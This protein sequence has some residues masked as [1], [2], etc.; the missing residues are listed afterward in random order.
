MRLATTDPVAFGQWFE[1]LPAESAQEVA[2]VSFGVWTRAAPGAA[3]AY[4]LRPG[5]PPKLLANATDIWT[6]YEPDRATAWLAAGAKLVWVVYPN[7]RKVHVHQP[8]D[9][10]VVLA[11]NDSLE[12]PGLF[13]G[14][15]MK[16]SEIFTSR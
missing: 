14:W 9:N 16:V 12:A 3:I 8:G 10:P 11:E 7:T 4:A 13:P 15:S 6:F 2:D 1:T 5:A